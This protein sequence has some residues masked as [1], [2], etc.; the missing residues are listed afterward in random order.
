MKNI[1]VSN[2]RGVQIFL[3]IFTVITFFAL[4]H[5]D[6]NFKI[7]GL[8]ILGYFLYG[9]LGIVITFHRQLTHESYSTYP[10]ITKLFSIFGCLAMT[11]S[12]IAWVAIH[13]NHHLKSDKENDPH[14]PLHKGWRIFLLNYQ[15]NIDSTTKWRMRHIVTDK[16]HQF[17]HRYYFLINILYSIVLFLIGGFYLMIFLHW[18]PAV[19]TAGMSNIVNYVGHQPSWLGSFRTY[20]ISDKSSNNWLWALPSWGESWHNNHHRH[21]KKSHFGE[22]WYQI[23]ISGIF[24][25]V[26]KI[27]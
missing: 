24:I 18:V 25:N 13:I 22:K 7:L 5:F 1:F 21:P 27:R 10:F 8:I 19:L 9:C 20:N 12:S 14:S 2:T 23:D 4:L 16:F 6:L 17:L 26:I 11:G 3:S 15:T